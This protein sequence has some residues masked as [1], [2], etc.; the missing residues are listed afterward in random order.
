[1]AATMSGGRQVRYRT[2]YERPSAR[3]MGQFV[4]R[5]HSR[6]HDILVASG[7]EE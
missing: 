3:V 7:H 6:A 2:S 1:M 4:R 5:A